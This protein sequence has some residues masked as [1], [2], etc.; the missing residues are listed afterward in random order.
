MQNQ[1]NIIEIENLSKTFPG[2]FEPAIK[3]IS[4]TIK[5]N[6]IFG[7]LGTNGAGKTTTI[8]I[9]CGIVK[10][11]S[12]KILMNGKPLSESS[13]KDNNILGVVPQDIALYP[14]LTAR[15]NLTFFGKMYGINGS[16]LEGK[17]E[18]WLAKMQMTKH[19]D[20]R[21]SKY[22]GRECNL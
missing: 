15:E 7:L 18:Y 14:L 16:E 21:V 20:T 19:A 3:D 17:I 10:P 5:R 8:S 13:I 6:E 12:G 9:L 2:A 1:D 11:T 4:F 22:S